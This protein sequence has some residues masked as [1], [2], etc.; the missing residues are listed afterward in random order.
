M[1]GNIK[2][3]YIHMPFCKR[4]C[5]YCD[6]Y[7]ISNVSADKKKAYTEAVIKEIQHFSDTLVKPLDTVYFGGGSP[8]MA[9]LDNL[10]SIINVISP[11]MDKNTEFSVELNPEH[12]EGNNEIFDLGFNR[13]SL[14]VQTTDPGILKRIKREYNADVLSINIKALQDR[15]INLSLDFMF[16]LPGQDIKKLK[17]DIDFIKCKNPDHLSFYLFTL[18]KGHEMEAECAPE[19]LVDEMFMTIHNGLTPLGYD[20]YEVSNY[21]VKGKECRHNM[22]YWERR[23]YLGIGAAAHSFIKEKKLRSWHAKDVDSYIMKE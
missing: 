8:F 9:G 2:H 7:S 1:A 10:S 15:G 17:N 16:G 4:K 18:P 5:S 12:I 19:D 14:G 20:H 21:A 22:A 13:V 11:Y 3:L 6:F 23:S